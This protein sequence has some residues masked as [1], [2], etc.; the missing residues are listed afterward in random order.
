MP[1]LTENMMNPPV[2]GARIAFH[3][4]PQP[5]EKDSFFL[6]RNGLLQRET[7]DYILAGA[8]LFFVDPPTTEDTLDLIYP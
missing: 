7:R 1:R 5:A 8:T 3:L 2:D 4:L 6:Y